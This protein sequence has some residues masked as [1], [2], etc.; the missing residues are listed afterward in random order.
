MANN[1]LSGPVVTTALANLIRELPSRK[2]NYRF[3]FVPET[4]G[5]ITFI[6]ENL[7]HL[8]S[9]VVGGFVLTCIGD[10]RNYSYLQS[11]QEDA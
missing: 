4:I 5:A 3:V 9:K 7:A 11:K 1:E 2:Y 8:K 10:E 6:S